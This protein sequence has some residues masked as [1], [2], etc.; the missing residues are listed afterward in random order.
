MNNDNNK[1]SELPGNSI[2]TSQSVGILFSHKRRGV[3]KWPAYGT[4]RR[5][6]LEAEIFNNEK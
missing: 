6:C 4:R 1:K 2:T 5:I 3:I